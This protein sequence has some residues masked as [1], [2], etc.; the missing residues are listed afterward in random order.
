MSLIKP[1]D[2]LEYSPVSGRL[3]AACS[4]LTGPTWDGALV[5]ED[6]AGALLKTINIG[7]GANNVAWLGPKEKELLLC[8]CDDGTLQIWAALGNK[9]PECVKYIV[10]HDDVATSVSV[11]PESSEIF[12]SSSWDMTIKEWDLTNTSQTTFRGHLNF[13]WDVEWNKKAK[14][15]FISASQDRTVKTWDRRLKTPTA[16]YTSDLPILTVSWNPTNEHMF[17]FGDSNGSIYIYDTRNAQDALLASFRGHTAGIHKIRFSPNEGETWLA[18]A[19]DDTMVIVW[20]WKSLNSVYSNKH[21]DFARA[22]AW[23][24]KKPKHLVSG[25]WDKTVSFHSFL[26]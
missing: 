1:C 5:V 25:G 22:L 18:T 13:V 7:A 24:P 3:A 17:A 8:S 19:S 11:R 6:E 20:D 10:E 15:L 21:E 14:D 23:N 26:Q 2:A 12:L 16:D 4:S 9:K